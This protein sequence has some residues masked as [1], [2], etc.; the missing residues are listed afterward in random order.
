MRRALLALV[1]LLGA[2]C[3]PPERPDGLMPEISSE[4]SKTGQRKPAARP[5]ALESALLPPMQLDMPKAPGVEL[6]QRFDLTV[7]NAPAS[8]VFMSIVAGTRYSM[9]VHPAVTGMIDR[10]SVV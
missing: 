7:T 6:D 3:T 8:Q 1:A 2:G 9:L 4:L 10:K 5:D